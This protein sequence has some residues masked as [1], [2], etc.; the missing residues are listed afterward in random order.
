[1]E[2]SF[3]TVKY[4]HGIQNGKELVCLGEIPKGSQTVKENYFALA[5]MT[6]ERRPVEGKLEGELQ[7]GTR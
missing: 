6:V 7:A 1:L 2:L 3:S 4:S 5:V